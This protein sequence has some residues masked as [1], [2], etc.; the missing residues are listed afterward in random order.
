ME[1]GSSSS[2]MLR[3]LFLLQIQLRYYRLHPLA[4]DYL[5]LISCVNHQSQE[6]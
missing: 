2:E 6:E 4:T 1:R 5:G 3:N